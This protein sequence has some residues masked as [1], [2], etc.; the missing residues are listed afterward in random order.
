M[1]KMGLAGQ[2][3]KRLPEDPPEPHPPQ[4]RDPRREPD[5]QLPAKPEAPRHRSDARLPSPQMSGPSAT[6]ASEDRSLNDPAKNFLKADPGLTGR[7]C[8][9]LTGSRTD[10]ALAEPEAPHHRAGIRFASPQMSGPSAAGASEDRSLN[11]AAKNFLKA[12]P[13][14]TGHNCGTLAGS[15]ATSHRQK[16]KPRDT[17]PTPDLR[18]LR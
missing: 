5:D 15:R 6:G 3:R 7:D 17:G 13:G 9:A 8:G 10:H 14:L 2:R 1:E 4:L 11:D 12:D 18:A 16:R